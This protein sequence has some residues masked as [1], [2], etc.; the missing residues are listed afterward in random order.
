MMLWPWMAVWVACTLVALSPSVHPVLG[1]SGW[2]IPIAGIGLWRGWKAAVPG[3][4][5]GLG[6]CVMLAAM[7]RTGWETTGSVAALAGSI[8]SIRMKQRRWTRAIRILENECQRHRTQN[9]SFH[10]E[11]QRWMDQVKQLEQIIQEIGEMYQMSKRFLGTFDRQEGLRIVAEALER[12]VPSLSP[13]ER[14]ACLARVEELMGR[15]EIRVEDLIGLLPIGVEDRTILEHWGMICGQLA[16]GLERIGLYQRVQE[17]ATHDSL[18]GLTVRWV[19]LGQLTEEIQ[20]TLRHKAT[21]ALLMVDLDRFKQVNDTYGHLV[22]DVVLREVANRLKTA[23]REMDLVC[24]YGGEEFAIALPYAT[25]PL[26]L[27]IA[28]R[29]RQAVGS[30]TIAAYDERVSIT[31]SVGVSLCPDHAMQADGLIEQADRALYQAKAQG[32]NRVVLA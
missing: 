27:Q 6:I 13:Q 14:A 11:K 3:G 32:R 19:F 1:M 2:M 15:G 25:R 26:A 7:G 5:A 4:I 9:A 20:R 8:L 10:S 17:M 21:L 12:W 28:E 22:G 29:I 31:V 18:T 16:L 23:V 30:S 24:R